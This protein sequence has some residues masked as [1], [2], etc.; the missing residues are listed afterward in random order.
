M[1][2][3]MKLFSS[4]LIIMFGYDFN[5]HSNLSIHRQHKPYTDPALAFFDDRRYILFFKSKNT[6][7]L[8]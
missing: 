3:I 7:E 6:E 5:V 8:Q 1:Q 2:F 4:I